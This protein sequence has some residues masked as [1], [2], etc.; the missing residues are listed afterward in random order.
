MSYLQKKS[1]VV[2]EV[3]KLMTWWID[4]RQNKLVGELTDT[5]SV[6][7]FLL[8]FLVEYHSLSSLS[9]LFNLVIASHLITGHNTGFGKLIDE[10]ILPE[11]FGTTKLTKEFRRENKPFSDS[12]FDEIDHIVKKSS[13]KIELLS[14]KAGRW[15]IQLTM[16]VQ[17][18]YAFKEII[19]KYPELFE[20]IDVGVFYGTADK[21]TDKYDI[22]R[23]INRGAIHDVA[24]LRDR[25]YVHV[26][27][28]FWSWINNGEAQTQDWVLA[29]ILEGLKESRIRKVNKDLLRSF[30]AAVSKKL[31]IDSTKQINEDDWFRLLEKINGTMSK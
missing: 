11:V 3:K 1:D 4:Q 25:V 18:N 9:E 17:L 16:A 30:E 14:L 28:D 24:D 8:P 23:G 6:N 27:A 15:T 22:L 21:L 12:C 31:D 5:M 2:A 7:P 26:G 29:G 13:G 10:K 19:T 20:S